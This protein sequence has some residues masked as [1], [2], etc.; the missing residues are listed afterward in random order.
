VPIRDP[1]A[2]AEA[3]MRC[4]ELRAQRNELDIQSLQQSF[5]METFAERLIEHL[6]S[7]DA[8]GAR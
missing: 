7:I 4:Y 6:K 2:A 5:S 1:Q 3:I 8:S